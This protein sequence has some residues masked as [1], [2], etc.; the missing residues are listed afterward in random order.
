MRFGKLLGLFGRIINLIHYKNRNN[1]L[2]DEKRLNFPGLRSNL[3][4]ADKKALL[5]KD[6]NEQ[7][8]SFVLLN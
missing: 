1:I 5:T 7:K 3:N 8:Q 4:E 6:R 2:R